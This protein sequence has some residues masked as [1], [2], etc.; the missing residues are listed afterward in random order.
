MR[1]R[2]I[3]DLTVDYRLVSKSRHMIR[4]SGDVT[5]SMLH[6]VNKTVKRSH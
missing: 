5:E 4:L 2:A 3:D 6:S 1:Q